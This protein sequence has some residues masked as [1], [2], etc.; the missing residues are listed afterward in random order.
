MT[1]FGYKLTVFKFNVRLSYLPRVCI[2]WNVTW[3]EKNDEQQTSIEP[4]AVAKVYIVSDSV[5]LRERYLFRWL[6]HILP[7]DHFQEMFWERLNAMCL[8]IY[9]GCSLTFHWTIQRCACVWLRHFSSVYEKQNMPLIWPLHR[10][11]SVLLMSFSRSRLAL[12]I[13]L[14]E[15]GWFFHRFVRLYFNLCFSFIWKC[16]EGTFFDSRKESIILQRVLS[17]RMNDCLGCFFFPRTFVSLFFW[18]SC[19]FCIIRIKIL[20]VL[21]FVSAYKKRKVAIRIRLKIE[22][23][24]MNY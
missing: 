4:V 22:F 6:R 20:K 15:R 19:S 18:C 7:F 3:T 14:C 9:F 10:F 17:F 23:T 21:F 13:W 11:N 2:F 8:W 24:Q 5:Q 12:F 1:I 16:D